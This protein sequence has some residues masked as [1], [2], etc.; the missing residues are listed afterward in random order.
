[1][2]RL[3]VISFFWG[4][5]YTSWVADWPHTGCIYTSLVG[6]GLNLRKKKFFPP[7]KRAFLHY[8]KLFISSEN[9]S[10]TCPFT[11]M[12]NKSSENCYCISHSSSVWWP[13]SNFLFYASSEILVNHGWALINYWNGLFIIFFLNSSN[14]PFIECFHSRDLVS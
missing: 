12:S 9:V 14:K 11:V 13:H 7:A 4:R 2:T 1:M 8:N 6:K 10:N 3:L 5:T